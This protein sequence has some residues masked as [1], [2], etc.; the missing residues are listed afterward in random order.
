MIKYWCWS[1]VLRC[2]AAAVSMALFAATSASAGTI[3]L[4]FG[5][6]SVTETASHNGEVWNLGPYD[7]TDDIRDILGNS[8]D[9]SVTT[10]AFSSNANDAEG[11]GYIAGLDPVMK[12]LVFDPNGGSLSVTIT[13]LISGGAYQVDV[14][15]G[16]NETT[17]RQADVEIDGNT[18]VVGG[19]LSTLVQYN[20][21]YDLHAPATLTGIVAIDGSL[22]LTVSGVDGDTALL[23]GIT[24]T[25]IPE[26][27]SLVL[28]ALTGVACLRR[29]QSCSA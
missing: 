17:D 29:H 7:G 9:V 28:L 15:A 8:T 1:R 13:G 14:Y 16:Q 22:L 26:P 4:S 24:L 23:Q 5:D 12:S 25:A 6:N 10:A 20:T 2:S 27:A 11:S 21:L 3:N 18:S 19:E